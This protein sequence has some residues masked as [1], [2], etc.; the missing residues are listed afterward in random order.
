MTTFI[1]EYSPLS[2]KS[3]YYHSSIIEPLI[4]YIEETSL[5]KRILIHGEFSSGKTTLLNCIQNDVKDKYEIL[6]LYTLQECN[7]EDFREH[8]LH[9]CKMIS[10]KEKMIIVD[11]IEEFKSNFQHMISYIIETYDVHIIAT[12]LQTI[13]VTPTLQK[14]L[15]ILY[16]PCFHID[17][18]KHLIH[19][20]QK[21]KNIQFE[22]Q[23][24]CQNTLL[25][26]S[27]YSIRI[28]YSN[29]EKLYYICDS[30]ISEKDIH[31]I[32]C[33]LSHRHLLDFTHACFKDKNKEKVCEI[34]YY[35]LQ[36]G[37]SVIDFL[38]Q[39]LNF[40]KYHD[41]DYI[42]EKET[43]SIIHILS[44]YIIIFH[45]IHENEIELYLFAY[46]LMAIKKIT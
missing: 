13:Q 9:F 24:N 39:Y 43:C 41:L 23:D 5:K 7:I 18:L 32:C 4:Q 12:C 6:D 22:D 38:E 15:H 8:I 36:Y 17:H 30:K 2:L 31:Q 42:S 20:I 3:F 27:N 21:D 44:K 25:Q 14:R 33:I 45:S 35:I 46:E 11:N 29:L 10:N 40:I 34:I 26:L 19:R 28:L 37:Y 1:H 16:I